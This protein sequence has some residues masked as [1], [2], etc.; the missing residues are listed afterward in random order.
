MA[1]LYPGWIA[2]SWLSAPWNSAFLLG[3]LAAAAA[4]VSLRLHLWFTALTFPQQF[5]D[6]QASTQRRTQAC[7]VVFAAILIAAA[8]G[9]SNGHPAFAMIFVGAAVAIV[10]AAFVIEPATARAAFR[11]R[12]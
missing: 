8:L 10:I 7:D 11:S 6:Q 12:S 3:L 9:I 5:A 2:R 1:M 4:A